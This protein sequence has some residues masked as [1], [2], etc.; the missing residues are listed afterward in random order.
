MQLIP[1]AIDIESYYDARLNIKN[2]GAINYLDD[3]NADI[4]LLSVAGNDGLRWTGR[5]EHFDFSQFS[6]RLVIAHNSA[7]DLGFFKARGLEMPP[8]YNCTAA[9]A[10]W[11]G[12]GRKLTVAAKHHLG[13]TISKDLRDNMKGRTWESLSPDEQKA[14]SDY[15]RRDAELSLALW[16]KLSPGWPLHEQQLSATTIDQGHYGILI[17]TSKLKTQK[18]RAQEIIADVSKQ[19]PWGGSGAL[20]SLHQCRRHCEQLGIRPPGSLAEDNE[21]CAAWELEFGSDYPFVAAIRKLRKANKLLKKMEAIERR[22]MPN[23]RMNYEIKYF[24]SHTGRW[25]G[26]GGVNIQ[27]L[28]KE[29]WEN[30]YLREQLVPSPGHKFIACDLSQIEPRCLA[31]VV[32]DSVLLDVIRHGY[33]V[34]EAMAISWGLWKG[35]AGTLKRSDPKMYQL[36]KLMC[37]GAGYGCGADKFRNKC[38]E[39][40]IYMSPEEATQRIQLFRRLNPKIVGLWNKFDA[41][42]RNRLRYG[43]AILKLPSGRAV[44]YP[45]LQT[46]WDPPKIRIAPDGS[47]TIITPGRQG[48][49]ATLPTEKGVR[50]TWLWGGVITE[51]YIQAI[52]RDI[53]A[54]AM[55]RLEAAGFRIVLHA[56]DE[57]VVEVPLDTNPKEIERLMTIG[58]EWAKDLPLGAEATEMVAYAK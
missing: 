36:M 12:S 57:A 7:F 21:D 47:R 44:H 40:E 34:Y 56:H 29:P 50:L 54:D 1:T 22:I 30:I 31:W 32:G 37:L 27:N 6:N 8:A 23:G 18:A 51:N 25:S 58:P 26:G 9:L 11:S 43:N 38:A 15:N 3:E 45:N 52:A 17:D 10:A 55:L 41:S 48:I 4:Y 2:S 5:P 28:E 24:G 49:V 33:A 20:Q 19:I 42:L 14:F 53:F 13:V 39:L 16:N 46:R 35:S